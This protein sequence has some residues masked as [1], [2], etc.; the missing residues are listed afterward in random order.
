[1]GVGLFV[2]P[3]HFAASTDRAVSLFQHARRRNRRRFHE[4]SPVN[5]PDLAPAALR[6]RGRCRRPERHEHRPRRLDAGR[7]EVDRHDDFDGPSREDGLHPHTFQRDPAGTA[8]PQQESSAEDTPYLQL[9]GQGDRSVRGGGRRR[10]RRRGW[11]RRRRGRRP[12]RGRRRS[13]CWRA[14]WRRAW[15][16]CGR[17]RCRG[18]RLGRRRVRGRW[19]RTLRVER[20]CR[21]SR[22]CGAGRRR[23][24][25]GSCRRCVRLAVASIPGREYPEHGRRRDDE[26]HPAGN[27]RRDP[28]RPPNRSV[29]AHGDTL[30]LPGEA[31]KVQDGPG[32]LPG[33]AKRPLS[34]RSPRHRP[35]RRRR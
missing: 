35:A 10:W 18:W 6:T 1:M 11:R 34:S 5:D 22:R 14:C 20:R 29:R 17:R 3:A 15:R 26:R 19:R 7:G 9:P 31:S 4:H 23:L 21:G 12:W 25:R 30:W 32:M 13:R 28:P 2:S 27:C 8:P 33:R 24:R 16:Q